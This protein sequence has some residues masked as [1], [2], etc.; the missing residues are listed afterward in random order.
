VRRVPQPFEGGIIAITLAKIEVA[1]D[2]IPTVLGTYPMPLN[3]NHSVALEMGDEYCTQ[4]H[5]LE[6]REVNASYGIIIDHDAHT[7]RG[8]TCVSCHNRVAHPEEGIEYQQEGNRHHEDWM[9]MD[10]CF[11]CHGLQAGAKAPVSAR[12]VTRRSSTSSRKP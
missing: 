8:V 7:S 2:L 5:S 9:S 10:A 1:P 3:E 6:T 12:H 4:C 11:R